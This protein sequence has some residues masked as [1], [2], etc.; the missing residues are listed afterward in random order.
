[1]RSESSLRVG[2][3]AIAL[4]LAV[5]GLSAL[6]FGQAETGTISGRVTDGTGAIVTA[7]KVTI[8]NVNTGL[9][10]E[11]ATSGIGEYTV[12]NLPSGSYVVL[13]NAQGFSQYKRPVDVTVGSA[14]SVDARLAVGAS[15]TVLEVTAQVAGSEV[16][17]ETQT[18][19]ATITPNQIMN[20]PSLTRDPYDF[21]ATAGNVSDG[22]G[23]MR[24]VGVSING[25]R[26]ASTNILLDGAENVDLFTAGVG[27]A[28]PLDSV[29]EY[30]LSTSNFTADYG[31]A[32]GGVVNVATKSGTNAFHGSAYEYNRISALASQTYETDALKSAGNT[33]PNSTFVRNQFGYSIGG[34]A[35][36]DK[37]FF[38]S[39]T[40]WTRIRSSANS[41]AYVFTPQFI[42]T[43]GTATQTYFSTYGKLA[44]GVS[45][46]GTPVLAG[47]LAAN[48]LSP[49]SYANQC[50]VIGPIPP[51]TQCPNQTGWDAGHRSP[52]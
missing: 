31:R 45:N 19:G 33:V 48:E 21:V 13:V 2:V 23:G 22:G 49:Y 8:K 10:R 1:M 17:T 50:S 30:K 5:L 34:P 11:A 12:T 15:G 24:G 26:S 46:I 39:N 51:A 47:L 18:I 38:F 4:V 44:S 52:N 25:Q 42:A 43:T 40:E 27:Q 9:T 29:Q 35:I 32:S 36:K 28:V 20:L 16:D 7:A 37:L 3:R 14:V 6:M 41:Q